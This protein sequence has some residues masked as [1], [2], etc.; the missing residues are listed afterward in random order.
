MSQDTLRQFLICSKVL[1]AKNTSWG[2]HGHQYHSEIPLQET[3]TDGFDTKHLLRCSWTP[4]AFGNTLAGNTNGWFWYQAPLKVC[5]DAFWEYHAV[6]WS[7]H[8]SLLPM[9]LLRVSIE[10]LLCTSKH[11]DHDL[12]VATRPMV[13]WA[14]TTWGI[15]YSFNLF[16]T[17]KK[18]RFDTPIDLHFCKHSLTLRVG[19]DS[20]QKYE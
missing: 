10:E 14:D 12:N 9:V 11:H 20:N 3:P 13:T 18:S 5:L 2:A 1:V 8:P 6:Y 16:Y 4:I 17:E 7:P 15:I 19:S